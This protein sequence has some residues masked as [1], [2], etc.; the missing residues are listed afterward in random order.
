MLFHFQD[1]RFGKPRSRETQKPKAMST[2]LQIFGQANVCKGEGN[3]YTTNTEDVQDCLERKL[4]ERL[5][6]ICFFFVESTLHECGMLTWNVSGIHISD[7]IYWNA[8]AYAH[9]YQYHHTQIVQVQV[10]CLIK[11]VELP[12][13]VKGSDCFKIKENIIFFYTVSLKALWENMEVIHSFP[14]IRI[15][16]VNQRHQRQINAQNSAQTTPTQARDLNTE[17]VIQ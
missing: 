2:T 9:G 12:V 10:Q 4:Q 13:D 7:Q 1:S 16:Q 8:E 11:Q 14:N 17:C 15:Q 3:P 6:C 5:Q